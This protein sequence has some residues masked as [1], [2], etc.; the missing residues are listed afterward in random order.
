MPIHNP[1]LI[2][3][4]D[5]GVSQGQIKTF[6]FVGAG[7]SVTVLNAIATVSISGGAGGGAITVEVDVSA[8]ATW[9]G[10]F[11]ITDAAIGVGSKLL[12]W[13]APGPYTGKGTLADEAELQPISIVTVVPA[14]GSALVY[15]QTPPMLTF[16]K[17]PKSTVR[18]R[19]GAT[20]GVDGNPSDVQAIVDGPITRIGKVRGNIKFTYMVM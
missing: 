17:M 19:P 6:D 12:V 16:N 9:R 8:I 10:K 20:P 2:D 15:W 11:T 13:Q 3:T 4:L 5:E 14:L 1:S 18:G 7:V